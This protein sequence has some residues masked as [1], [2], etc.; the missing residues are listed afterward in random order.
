LS[1]VVTLST[2]KAEA[3][4]PT[5]IGADGTVYAIND[6]ILGAIGTTVPKGASQP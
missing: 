2:G 6:A 3:Y 5:V 1:E 4:T